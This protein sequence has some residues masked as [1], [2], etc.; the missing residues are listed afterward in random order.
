[1]DLIGLFSN[2][3]GKFY[4]SDLYFNRS[5]KHYAV[6]TL[7]W[8]SVRVY[9]F[10]QNNN[11]YCSDSENWNSHNNKLFVT[12][13]TT[14]IKNKYLFIARSNKLHTAYRIT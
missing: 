7:Y 8:V 13:S 4:V 5:V 1:M 14:I 12:V 3:F 11:N 9:E 6:G 10:T 2:V